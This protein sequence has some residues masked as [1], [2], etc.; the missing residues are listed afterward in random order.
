MNHLVECLKVLSDPTRLKMVRF[1]L[2][3]DLYVCELVEVMGVAQ[4]TISQHLRRLKAV[5]LVEE[6]KEGQRVRYR[7][8]QGGL[9]EFQEELRR[10]LATALPE[11]PQMRE[12]WK[13]YQAFVAGGRAL[14]TCSTCI[15]PG[16]TG[17]TEEDVEAGEEEPEP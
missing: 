13:R 9:E 1:L 14:S 16:E 2:E 4:P 5:R 7:L 6:Q 11:I 8:R 12:E 10:F 15:L 3:R 17:G